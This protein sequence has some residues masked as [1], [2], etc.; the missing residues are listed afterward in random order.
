MQGTAITTLKILTPGNVT[1]DRQ[2]G[3][4]GRIISRGFEKRAHCIRP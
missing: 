1:E 2:L 4:V 3:L